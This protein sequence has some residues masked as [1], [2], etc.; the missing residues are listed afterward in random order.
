M[1]W[2][3]RLDLAREGFDAAT[4]STIHRFCQ[5]MLQ[6]NAFE[7]G[8]RFDLTLLRDL[9]GLRED[10]LADWLTLQGYGT[11]DADADAYWLSCLR[12]LRLTGEGLQALARAAT[13]DRTVRLPAD[14]GA[15]L[16]DW[17]AAVAAVRAAAEAHDPVA[18][19]DASRGY[20]NGKIYSRRYTDTR[21]REI[22]AWLAGP[23]TP[24]PMKNQKTWNFFTA[25]G[26]G[27]N[28]PD[29]LL[30]HPF[31]KAW[32]GLQA[33]ATATAMAL[34]TR[35]ARSLRAQVDAA[36][37]RA[38]AQ[39]FDDLLAD[40]DAALAD[41][42]RG[43]GLRSI[44]RDRFSVAL[45]DEFQ[46]T[47]PLQWRVFRSLFEQR[48]G[49]ESRHRLVLIGDPKQAIYSFRGA[50]VAVYLAA[51]A[52]ADQAFT[53][54]RNFRSDRPLVDGLN[55]LMDQ[56]GLFG[57]V[58]PVGAGIS[59][60]PVT[61]PERDPA[62]RLAASGAPVQIRFLGET[63]LDGAAGWSKSD[64]A[65]AVVQDLVRQ[66]VAVLS[67]APRIEDAAA[68]GG[69]RP[70]HPGDLAV[71]TRS[72]DQ[73]LRVWHALVA[74]GVPAVQG[75]ASS[76]FASPA[77]Q[78]LQRWLELVLRPRQERRARA[79][80]ATDLVGFRAQDLAALPPK[81]WTTLLEQALHWRTLAERHG[82]MRSFR[83][84]MDDQGVRARLLARQDG[85]RRLTDLLHLVE[86][87]HG[88]ERAEGRGLAGLLS[89]LMAQREDPVA[90]DE[91]GEA[92]LETDARAVRL[93]T[94]H[95]SKGLEFPI[96]FLPF[97]W[98]GRLLRAAQDHALVVPVADNER[99][100][101][102]RLKALR[103]PEDPA[104]EQVK[105]AMRQESMRLLYVA[106]TR[107]RHRVVLWW[108]A[109]RKARGRGDAHTSPLAVLLHGAGAA[110]E[111][112]FQHAAKV[113]EQSGPAELMESLRTQAAGSSNT[114]SVEEVDPSAP[115]PRWASVQ[116]T[117]GPLTPRS[118]VGLSLDGSWG[119][120]SYSRLA[121]RAGQATLADVPE[122]EGLDLDGQDQSADPV[123]GRVEEE[124][125]VPL[126]AFPA[127]RVAGTCL[128]AFFETMDFRDAGDGVDPEERHR[129]VLNHLRQILPR[130]G[131]APEEHATRSAVAGLVAALRTPLGGP[132]GA[133]RLCDLPRD[134]RFDELRFELPLTRGSHWQPGDPC[135]ASGDLA[136]ALTAGT[137]PR[138]SEAYT[139]RLAGE[140]F[141]RFT[142]AGFLTGSIDLVF[143]HPGDGRFYVVDYKSN[144]I[145]P[146]RTRRYPVGRYRPEHL[147]AEMESHHYPVQYLLYTTALHRYLKHRLGSA[148][149]Y[150]DAIGGVYYLFFRGMVG[151]PL[152]D[153]EA[154]HGVFFDAPEEGVIAAL[155]STLRGPT[156][157]R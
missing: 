89:W 25:Q 6:L 112:R 27:P 116:A 86:L 76:V 87:L 53:M 148:Y 131:F 145:D 18:A 10:A 57:P 118:R 146:E 26:F 75:Q 119:L 156:E 134:A 109:F 61:T 137:Q 139:E 135:V 69:W 62:A 23:P 115:T 138:W 114:V 22:Q 152:V 149:R 122:Q 65:A 17:L 32:S 36:L 59:Y 130:H 2:R 51:R 19:I 102:V 33:Q 48:S 108:G 101:D 4:I 58:G 37:D 147:S 79:F 49:E 125:D 107:A 38:Y 42:D 126:A 82:V 50:N 120:H 15:T 157:A 132:A 77:A 155:D 106:L 143:R 80:A 94:I 16:H 72:N 121:R 105:A 129:R 154:P 13:G 150:S 92:R 12:D 78:D 70:V 103:P 88:V 44:I 110:P 29:T 1:V 66:V 40:L 127:G 56:P 98:D 52:A 35:A 46:D 117:A 20:L 74:A 14:N 28:A 24:V 31:V 68:P 7:S 93:L 9:S 47:D 54:D 153:G 64:A 85:E 60:V 34:R 39:G 95:K 11:G 8:T 21:W 84:C 41:P 97:L 90:A 140:P 136:A 55:H 100:L 43:P 104:V 123:P 67:E 128:H 113:V 45:I 91:S 30:E 142:L 63:G 71:L 96:V 3:R 141:G 83:R 73:A 5:R 144:R 124:P 99:Q 111:Q 151:D 133:L 81:R